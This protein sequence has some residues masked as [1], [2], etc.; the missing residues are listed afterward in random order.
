MYALRRPASKAVLTIRELYASCRAYTDSLQNE[1]FIL[2]HLH[3]LHSSPLRRARVPELGYPALTC[4]QGG[5]LTRKA[6]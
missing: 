2:P 1:Q 4:A 3:I 6:I 5:R